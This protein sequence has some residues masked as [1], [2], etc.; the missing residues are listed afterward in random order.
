MPKMSKKKIIAITGSM[1]SGKSMVSSMIQKQYPVLDADQVNRDLLKAGNAVYRA[2]LKQ[3]SLPLDP[4]QEINKVD[5]SKKM[6]SDPAYREQVEGILHPLIMKTIQDWIKD[7]K[8]TLVFVEIPLLF[9][10]G[11]E[12]HFEEIWCVV[13]DEEV[14][15]ER[16]KSKRNI[17][18]EEAKARLACQY[19]PVIKMQKSDVV[20]YNNGTIEQLQEQVDLYLERSAT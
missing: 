9:E 19:S 15:L 1:G 17:S 13:C 10:A 16:L 20:L 14:A 11:M 6:F 2:L 7:Q 3:L 8:D 5:F 18:R 12:D 4:H